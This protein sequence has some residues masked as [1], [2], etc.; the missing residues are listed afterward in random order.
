MLCETCHS[1][2]DQ[3][4]GFGCSWVWKCPARAKLQGNQALLGLLCMDPPLPSLVAYG[5]LPWS[6]LRLSLAIATDLWGWWVC[7]DIQ[8]PFFSRNR[9][10]L[11][12]SCMGTYSPSVYLHLISLV[13]SSS[14]RW[15]GAS[16]DFAVLGLRSSN[17]DALGA[18]PVQMS[19][20]CCHRHYLPFPA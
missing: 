5:S 6:P 8:L 15:P 10:V 13:C 20:G 14:S 17:P 1:L 18:L 19:P 2:L 7:C 16:W 3:G 11:F 9:G 12:S 4:G